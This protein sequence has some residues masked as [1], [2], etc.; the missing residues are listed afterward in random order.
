MTE[1]FPRL[2]LAAVVGGTGV[3]FLLSWVV[4]HVGSDGAF[5]WELAAIFGTA[6]GTTLLAAT[7]GGLAYLTGR[8]VSATRELARLQ[9]A[10]QL[11]RERP[12]V[13][14]HTAGY[15]PGTG[16]GGSDE[17][18]AWLRNVGLGPALNVRVWAR[19]TTP[20]EVATSTPYRWASIAPGETTAI[21]LPIETTHGVADPSQASIDIAGSYTDRRRAEDYAVITDTR[22]QPLIPPREQDEE[23]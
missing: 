14:L 10:D 23:G 3:V 9:S 18:H 5:N 4:G 16:A 7:T 20:R 1:H 19:L 15:Q 17:I 12:T 2:L 22:S 21:K 11:A 6:L 13:L 8:D